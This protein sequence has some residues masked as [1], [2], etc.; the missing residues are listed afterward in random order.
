VTVNSVLV[1]G[2]GSAGFLTAIT[3]KH[4]LPDLPV[5]VLLSR[6]IGVIGVGEAT[7]LTLPQHLH[8]YLKLDLREFYARA[9]P[10]WKI[11]IRFLW[12]KRPFFDYAFGY[13]L[14]TQYAALPKVTGYYCRDT[15]FDYVGIPSG[16]MTENKG[17][18]RGPDGWPLVGGDVAYHLE[19]QTFVAYLEAEATRRGV[20]I[21]D[22]KVVGVDRDD[23]RVTGLRLASGRVT[24]ADLFVDCSG[25]A[26]VL[27]QQTL[28]EPFVSYADSLFCDRAV[29]G[30][31]DRTTEP[32]Q[33]YTTAE[34]MTTGWCWRID[35]EHRIHRGYVYC[36]AYISDADAEAEFR[37]KNPRLEG[38]R[39]WVVK[40]K[41]GRTERGWVGNVVA[42]GNSGGFV[43]PLESTAL[44]AICGHC[45]ALAE[46]LADA[47]REIRPTQ[48]AEYN[49]RFAVGW[50]VIRDFLSVHYRFNT[51]YDT[52]FWRHCRADV[53][54]AGAEPIVAYY[55]ENGPS[56]L[57]RKTLIRPEDQ[58]GMEGYL[59][60]LIGQQVPYEERYVPQAWEWEKWATI[61]R[62]IKAK[63]AQAFPVPDALR[64]LRDPRFRWPADLYKPRAI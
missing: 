20:V 33:P 32:I 3:L 31:W 58:F 34:S 8:D 46:T 6:E 27:L 36:S 4:R 26:G 37:A 52:P 62:A 10:Q 28:K 57:W 11:G 49:K 56:V 35:H 2:G 1:L 59:S 17:Y 22:D 42:I 14:D 25:F 41:S 5:T 7:T 12:G 53:N 19:N 18:L 61:R 43:E 38:Q 24:T 15:P 13:Q 40:F 64:A 9:E 30:G 51:R 54:L 23:H 55:R 16:L 50:D 45:Q 44:G 39:T 47:D 21:E 29:T 60:L 63:V 48:V